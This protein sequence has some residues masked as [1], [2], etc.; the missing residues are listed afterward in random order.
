MQEAKV[1]AHRNAQISRERYQQ[2][3][4]RRKARMAEAVKRKEEMLKVTDHWMITKERE[5]YQ[6]EHAL[7]VRYMCGM[8]ATSLRNANSINL[9]VY[10]DSV[11]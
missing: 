4:D 11:V 7:K 1:K 9:D 10:T 5:Q 8:L 6:E 3:E 2:V